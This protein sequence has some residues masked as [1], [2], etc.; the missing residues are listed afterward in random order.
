MSN[1]SR[2]T[3][4]DS[5]RTQLIYKSDCL[6]GAEILCEEWNVRK[7]ERT[8]VQTTTV[9][10]TASAPCRTKRRPKIKLRLPEPVNGGDKSLRGYSYSDSNSSRY[11]TINSNDSAFGSMGG[12]SCYSNNSNLT[13]SGFASGGSSRGALAMQFNPE[14]LSPHGVKVYE[15]LYISGETEAKSLDFLTTNGISSIITIQLKEL[16]REIVNRFDSSKYLHIKLSDTVNVNIKEHFDTA[17]KFID[18][19]ERTLIHCQAG[20]SRSATLCLAYMIKMRQKTLDQAFQDLK[21]CRRCIGPNFSFLGQLKSFEEEVF[22][23]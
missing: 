20:I 21:K 22:G 14:K 5:T 12:S 16:P 17:I 3:T 1:S 15:N 11:D 18:A 8:Q 2:T 4:T 10:T 19:N 23:K 13:D 9:I 7:E 6:Q